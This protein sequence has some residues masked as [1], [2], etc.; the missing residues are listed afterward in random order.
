MM[1]TGMGF[2]VH[3]LVY[4]RRLILGGV[5]I[6]HP[7]GLL[8]HSDADVLTHAVADALLGAAALGDLGKFFPDTDPR[9]RGVTS[10]LILAKTRKILAAKH[11]R[12]VNIDAIIAAEQPKIAPWREKICRNLAAVLRVNR[13]RI[14]VKATT[15]EHLG[16]VGRGEG[17][18]V[19]SVATI[20]D[21]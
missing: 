8:G 14:S 12:I 6:P 10:L 19:W 17:I 9:Y 11:F 4:D 2:D 13:S 1:R 15:T 7:K 16:F 20:T 3:P 5:R 21:Q 18:A